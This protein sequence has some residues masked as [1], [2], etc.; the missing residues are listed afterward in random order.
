RHAGDLRG[1]NLGMCG[2]VALNCRMNGTLRARFGPAQ[3]HVAPGAND[4]GTAIGAAIIGHR[5]LTGELPR[6]DLGHT[7]LGPAWSDEAIARSLERM[8]LPFQRLRDVGAQTAE[9][10]AAGKIVCW[11]QGP[12][13]FGPRALGGRSIL[14]D[15]RRD[16]LKP[17]LNAIKS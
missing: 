2:G 13:E 10:L 8:R 3:M 1:Q 6:L 7:H 14:A 16:D 17:R 12:M 11:F 4:A 15:P 9:L 5:E